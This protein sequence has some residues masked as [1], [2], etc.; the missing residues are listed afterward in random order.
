M[1]SLLS[2]KLAASAVSAFGLTL[3]DDADAATARTT[4]GAAAASHSHTTSDITNLSSYTGFD[5]RYYTETE[6][7]AL[8]AAKENTLNAD[9][10]RKITFSTSA[11]S[12]GS[13]GDIWFQYTA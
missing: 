3:I 10:K 11:A 7:D 2:A 5:A 6:A 1:D 8:L 13:D 9:Q 12:G 4:L